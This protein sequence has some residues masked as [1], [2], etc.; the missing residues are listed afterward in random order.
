[1]LFIITMAIGIAV[2]TANMSKARSTLSYFNLDSVCAFDST[3]IVYT[4]FA[5][6]SLAL[7]ANHNI[8][9]CGPCGKC[10]NAHD[11]DVYHATA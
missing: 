1:M 7:A 9:H 5:N 4:T 6:R 8:A 3:A 2:E 11:I 10:S